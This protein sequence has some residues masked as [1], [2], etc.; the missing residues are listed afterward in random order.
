[1]PRLEA[2]FYL[3]YGDNVMITKRKG[4]S[5]LADVLEEEKPALLILCHGGRE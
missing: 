5:H 3:P 2:A 1:M 4:L